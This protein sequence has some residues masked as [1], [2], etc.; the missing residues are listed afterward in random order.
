VFAPLLISDWYW[1]SGSDGVSM[2][3]HGLHLRLRDFAKLGQLV[4]D[5]GRWRDTRIVPESWIES[6]TSPQVESDTLDRDGVLFPYGYYWWIVPGVGFAAWGHGGQ[7]LLV[8]PSLRMVI[9]QVS[10]PDADLHG[11]SLGEFTELVRPLIL[12]GAIARLRRTSA[13]APPCASPACSASAML[14]AVRAQDRETI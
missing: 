8:V 6:S 2:G 7:I 12:T 11:S 3:A 13:A 4:L 9:A 14:G 10:L 5:R 1:G